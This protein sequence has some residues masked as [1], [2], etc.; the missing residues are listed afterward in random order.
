ME[1]KTKIDIFLLSVLILALVLVSLGTRSF[2]E[3]GTEEDPLVSQTYVEK[4]IDQLRYYIDEKVSGKN[5]L[6]IVEVEEGQSIIG[7][8][9]T[10]IILR[11]GKGK[12]IAGQLGG[13]CDVTDGKDLQMDENVPA[14]HMILIP[15]DDGRGIY[16]ADKLILMVMGEYEIK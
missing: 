4:R 7:S 6:E 10:E 12:V 1:R 14:N 2:S 16:A 3:P 15:R 11:G 9:G 8:S 13:I 5:K